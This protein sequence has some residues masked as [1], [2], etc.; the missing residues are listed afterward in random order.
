MGAQQSTQV[1]SLN[2][3]AFEEIPANIESVVDNASLVIEV[4]DDLDDDVETD[5]EE[6]RRILEDAKML[7]EYATYYLHPELPVESCVSARCYFDRPSAP[8]QESFEQ[9]EERHQILEECQALRNYAGYYL[10]PERRH[11]DTCKTMPEL[12]TE[13]DNVERRQVL[14]DTR[15]LKQYATFYLHPELPVVTTDYM[16]TERN[17]FN[18]PSAPNQETREE[19]EQHDAV[20][21]DSTLLKQYAKMYMHPELP[22]TTTDPTACARCYFGRPSAPQQETRDEMEEHARILE[23]VENLKL[24][25]KFYLHPELPVETR[26]AT[27]CARCYFDRPSAPDRESWENAEERH[28]ILVEAAQLEALAQMHLHNYVFECDYF[29]C[30]FAMDEDMVSVE[31]ENPV[32]QDEDNTPADL[33]N[34]YSEYGVDGH[35][36][37]SPSS[38]FRFA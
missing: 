6:R 17:Y 9:A 14:E 23:D 11:S 12:E 18:R 24:Y 35:M 25:A 13:D 3:K 36:S 10:H 33:V 4:T 15:L 29:H 16:A 32:A 1:T 8:Q 5:I 26:D 30:Q 27:A 28:L 38:I 7:K 22:V 2:A 21:R 19:M 31:G 34:K 37:R 20:L